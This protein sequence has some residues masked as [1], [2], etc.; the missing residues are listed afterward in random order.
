MFL[1]PHH[2]YP[3]PLP[4]PPLSISPCL[5]S[6]DHIIS[7]TLLSS[8]GTL[9]PLSLAHQLLSAA[10]AAT[11][12]LPPMQAAT[13]AAATA[14]AA[15]A[16]HG[17]GKGEGKGGSDGGGSSRVMAVQGGGR[18]GISSIG[19]LLGEPAILK[20]QRLWTGKQVRAG[21]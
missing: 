16:A 11:A 17:G 8:S 3:L 7:G 10:T 19:D 21:G 6:Q 14:A 9:L 2:S 12:A 13:T 18:G 5:H 4:L 20:P 1:N 15:A